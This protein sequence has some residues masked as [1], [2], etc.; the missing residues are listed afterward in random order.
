MEYVIAGWLEAAQYGTE[1]LAKFDRL[2]RVV[3][4]NPA[5]TVW[6]VGE[7]APTLGGRR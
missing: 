4:R 6:W 1:G 2:G 3:Y 5:V 7:Q